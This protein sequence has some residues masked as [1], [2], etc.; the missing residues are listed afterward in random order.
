MSLTINKRRCLTLLQILSL[1]LAVGALFY[2]IKISHSMN[3]LALDRCLLG[4]DELDHEGFLWGNELL[5]RRAR[6]GDLHTGDRLFYRFSARLSTATIK[7]KRLPLG[8]VFALSHAII[9]SSLSD[10]ASR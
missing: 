9:S 1:I 10:S 2:L 8:A 3:A 4:Q 5:P 6:V 7:K